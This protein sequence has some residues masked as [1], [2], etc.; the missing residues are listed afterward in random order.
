MDKEDTGLRC[1]HCTLAIEHRPIPMQIDTAAQEDSGIPVYCSFSCVY[2]D[3]VQNGRNKELHVEVMQKKMSD[4]GMN[5][6]NVKA[7]PP[8]RYLTLYGGKMTAEEYRELIAS[9]VVK[10]GVKHAVNWP[11]VSRIGT[12]GGGGGSGNA[13]YDAVKRDGSIPNRGRGRGK[14]AV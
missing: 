8:H 9:T 14:V 7:A 2:G 10:S 13:I 11:S 12:G 6:D 4:F 1:V 5:V 3:I